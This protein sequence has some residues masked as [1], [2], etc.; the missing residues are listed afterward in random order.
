[1]EEGVWEVTTV[2]KSKRMRRLR[3]ILKKKN[4]FKKK[5]EGPAAAFTRSIFV[6][7]LHYEWSKP[8]R[9]R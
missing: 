2:A 5:L 8:S 9:R 6:V 4:N 3:D 1:V 7:L